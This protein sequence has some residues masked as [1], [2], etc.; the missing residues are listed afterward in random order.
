MNVRSDEMFVVRS[1]NVN[2]I[3]LTHLKK[4]EILEYT[5]ERQHQRST[6]VHES[7]CSC[8][9]C[10][11]NLKVLYQRLLSMRRNSIRRNDRHPPISSFEWKSD[12][13]STMLVTR[14]EKNDLSFE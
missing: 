13:S 14:M 9:S 8:F 11:S 1:L 5:L 10:V 4:N 12:R 3:S 6:Q 2:C 7:V